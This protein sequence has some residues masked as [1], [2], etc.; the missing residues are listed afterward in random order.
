MVPVPDR[1]ESSYT[2]VINLVNLIRRLKAGNV[3]K[4]FLGNSGAQIVTFL[5]AFIL[6]RLYTPEQFGVLGVFLAI[7]QMLI[8]I[9]CLGYEAAIVITNSVIDAYKVCIICFFINIVFSSLLY[10]PIIVFEDTI[11]QLLNAEEIYPWLFL[12]P[13]CVFLGGT[14]NAL[15]YFNTKIKSYDDIAKSNIIKSFSCAFIQVFGALIKKCSG[16]LILGQVFMNLFGN[17]KLAKNLFRS[18][19]L[20]YLN[21]DMLFWV[22]KYRKFP[23]FYSWGV[24]FNTVSLNISNV[25]IKR[26]YTSSDVGYYSYS[27]RYIGFPISMISTAV[28]QVYFQ[29]LSDAKE[30]NPQKVFY[31]TLVKLIFIGLPIF[32]CLYFIIEP[33][34]VFAFGEQWRI[35]G[36]LAKIMIPLFFIRFVVSPLSLSLIVFEKQALLLLWQIGLVVVTVLPYTMS[37]YYDYNIYQY[38]Y[39]MTIYIGLYYVI[40]L[41]LIYHVVVRK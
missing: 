12:L 39:R 18:G 38:I 16:S 6:A 14:F 35:A 10:I 9:S 26:L 36:E 40:Y 5:A 2:T 1:R 23:L 30:D 27:Y 4:L 37:V 8:P 29:E 13:I 31:S 25:L 28:G 41:F 32:I 19:K 17:I 34:F 33:V 7:S 15:N 11:C 24:L 20:S 22:K 21:S 3:I